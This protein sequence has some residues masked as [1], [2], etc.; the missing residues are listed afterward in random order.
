MVHCAVLLQSLPQT[1]HSIETKHNCSALGPNTRLT[2][3]QFPTS[4]STVELASH[5]PHLCPIIRWHVQKVTPS[6]PGSCLCPSSLCS[7]SFTCYSGI[8]WPPLL[9]WFFAANLHV[10]VTLVLCPLFLSASANI[11][12]VG[13]MRHNELSEGIDVLDSNGNVVG[14]SKIAAKRVSYLLCYAVVATKLRSQNL[15]KFT[16]HVQRMYLVLFYRFMFY[17]AHCFLDFFKPLFIV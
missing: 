1:K 5:N 10:T 15:Q 6:K 4:I 3:V 11:C 14:S 13:L 12:N 2:W 17:C 16:V 8:L 9:N 7:V